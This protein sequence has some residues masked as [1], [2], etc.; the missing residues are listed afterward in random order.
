[1]LAEPA[2]VGEAGPRHDLRHGQVVAVTGL[3]GSARDFEPISFG[4]SEGRKIGNRVP[5]WNRRLTRIRHAA[6]THRD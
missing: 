2:L 4:T 3:V 1:M 5:H 6:E